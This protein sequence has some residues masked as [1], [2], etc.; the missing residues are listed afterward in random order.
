VLTD[1]VPYGSSKISQLYKNKSQSWGIF[2]G[3]IVVGFQRALNL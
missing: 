3:D 2:E 1:K